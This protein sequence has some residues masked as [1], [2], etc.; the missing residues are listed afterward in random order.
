MALIQVLVRPMILNIANEKMLGIAES[1]C[2]FGILVGS[3]FIGI[4][5]IKLSYSR[6][7]G[8]A[9]IISGI[10]ISL[11]GFSNLL[12]FIVIFIFIFLLLS[13]LSMQVL[14]RL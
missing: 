12:I 8:I 11:A 6:T 1:I 3:G 4:R 5:G 9:G 7:L 10:F 13:H 14:M 2:A